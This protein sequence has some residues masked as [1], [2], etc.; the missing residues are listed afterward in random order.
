M[1]NTDDSFGTRGEFNASENPVDPAID[2]GAFKYDGPP[3]ETMTPQELAVR[4]RIT[5]QEAEM[6]QAMAR[7]ERPGGDVV[8]E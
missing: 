8:K 7:G 2:T 6:F 4:L 5:V 1:P 3:M